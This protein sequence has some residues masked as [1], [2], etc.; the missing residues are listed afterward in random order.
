MRVYNTYDW[1]YNDE[2][3]C[4]C[5]DNWYGNWIYGDD[6]W[7]WNTWSYDT[8][9][10][11]QKS[12]KLKW[13]YDS[14]LSCW[15]YDDWYGMWDC[16]GDNWYWNTWANSNSNQKTKTKTLP[17]P[18]PK[19]KILKTLPKPPPKPKPKMQRQQ[20]Y[21]PH[22]MYMYSKSQ[23]K[24][25]YKHHRRYSY[26]S[27][28]YGYGSDGYGYG[29]DGYGYG[30]DGYGY[31]SD[32]YG[33]G[34]GGYGSDGYGSGGY[35]SGGYGSGAKRMSRRMSKSIPKRKSHITQKKNLKSKSMPKPMHKSRSRKSK[36]MPK[37]CC[38]YGSDGYG[39]GGY[40]SGGYG[41]GGYG[42]GGYG[43]GYGS[44]G[45]YGY[46]SGGYG[47]GGYGSGGYGSGG[48]GIR[49]S[50]SM[51]KPMRKS[52]KSKSM[53]K[54]MRKSRMSKSIPRKCCRYGSEGY[55]SG[56]YGSGDGYGS[57]YGSGGYGRYGK[58]K[59]EF[60]I[61]QTSTFDK[62]IISFNSD[63]DTDV[64]LKE[65]EKNSGFKTKHHLKKL[66]CCSATIDKN[67]INQLMDDPDIKYIEKDSI[68]SCSIY[69]KQKFEAK[70]I[71]QLWHQVMT[72]T[73]PIPTDNFSSVH[74]YILDTGILQDHVEF[75]SGQVLLDY[76]AITNTTGNSLDDNGHGTAVGSMVGGLTVG[77]A[78][79]T[80][81]HSIKVLD[82]TGS[83]YTSDIIAGLNWVMMN[84]KGPC[85]INLSLGGS[86]STTFNT[87]IQKCITA[88]ITVVCA[89]G[90]SGID[91]SNISPCNAVGSFSVSAYDTTKAETTW[92]NFGPV[93]STFAPGAGIKGAWGDSTSSYF[94][95][96]G[97][98]FSSP[99]VAGI[100]AR[101]LK[102]TPTAT[103]SQINTFLSK[104]NLNNEIIKI[105]LN[106]PNKRLVWNPNAVNTC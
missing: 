94:L 76:N 26:G 16:D 36:S 92:S 46:G 104:S 34:S 17:N 60:K 62:Y 86:F 20:A 31:G 49:K 103:Q 12:N 51:P 102:I 65:L 7:Y 19:P 71:G 70:L 35:G 59:K 80:M 48:Y 64:K 42:S 3:D 72:N 105:G 22:N 10:I 97:T 57:G 43:S 90:N 2:M 85:I 73:L 106:T 91:A 5:Y 24:Y 21:S 82:S 58:S 53:P 66:N 75:T 39:S 74:C 50:K 78:N 47:S 81:L 84:A 52:R 30:S 11:T 69:A 100:I 14:N 13:S 89:A 93:I 33:Y 96:S 61:K 98:S 77:I 44:G 45:G 25:K 6:D 29:S 37:K 87:A 79:K 83:G 15:Y 32:G 101:Y 23:S 95:I 9:K 55:G 56:G 99:I 38:R 4:W 18:P 67:L 68:L 41:S 88:G 8:T 63:I 1:V 40:G 54:P 28:G 27:D